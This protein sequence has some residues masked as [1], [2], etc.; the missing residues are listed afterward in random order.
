MATT[1]RLGIW[2][3]AADRVSAGQMQSMDENS[4]EARACRRWYPHVVASMLEGPH[5]WSFA[6]V[7][8]RLAE[9]TND[10]DPEWHRAYQLPSDCGSP[11]KVLPDLGTLGLGIPVPLTGDPYAE[12]WSGLGHDYAVPYLIEGDTLYT[13][14]E[15]ATLSYTLSNIEEGRIGPKLAEALALELATHLA[16]AVKKDRALRAEVLA[17]A[18]VAMAR[19]I[20]DDMNRQPQRDSH[21][22][23]EALL[24]RG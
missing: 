9:K 13:Q 10:R 3:M 15:N 11:G 7:R 17:E 2:N 23:S 14:A 21:Y 24:A 18:E 20:A 12:V 16:V 5:D 4:L 1:S 19:A 6:T 8:V 22:V